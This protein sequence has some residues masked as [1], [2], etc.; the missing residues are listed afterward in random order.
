VKVR[1]HIDAARLRP[2]D[3]P[4][5]LGDRSRVTSE[6][7]WEP[8]IPIERTLTDLLEYWRVRVARA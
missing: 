8:V 4:I 3:N 6:I 7:G 1:V 2:S 5:V